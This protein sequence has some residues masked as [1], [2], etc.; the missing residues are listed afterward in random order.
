MTNTETL[1][2]ICALRTTEKQAALK[3]AF[4]SSV[5]RF[6][7]RAAK[8]LGSRAFGKSYRVAKESFRPEAFTSLGKAVAPGVHH[9]ERTLA[10]QRG[11]EFLRT[12]KPQG[13][14]T[15]AGRV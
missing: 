8:A 13:F 4:L 15:Y 14:K 11:N 12:F 7:P 2:Q 6:L 3:E 1:A 10:L 5:S 9:T